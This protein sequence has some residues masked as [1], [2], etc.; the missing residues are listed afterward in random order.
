MDASATGHTPQEALLLRLSSSGREDAPNM[1]AR[2][3]KMG[4]AADTA[5]AEGFTALASAARVGALFVCKELLAHGASPTAPT[6]ENRNPPLFWAAGKG[7][8]EVVRLLCNASAS[9][10][11]QRNVQGDTALLWACR[12][13][14]IGV[15]ETLLEYCPELLGDS[16]EHGL[17]TLMCAA[18]GGHVQTLQL[19]L[20]RVGDVH[21]R[22]LV[23]EQD[24]H[25]RTALHFAV[26]SEACVAALLAAGADWRARDV[27]GCTP[28]GEALK[29]GYKRTAELLQR[30]WEREWA[31]SEHGRSAVDRGWSWELER[32]AATAEGAP[33]APCGP[34]AS[35]PTKRKKKK[36]PRVRTQSTGMQGQL[37]ATPT[38]EAAVP[39]GEA[40]ASTGEAAVPTGVEAEASGVA[41]LH[42]G[43]AEAQP[44]HAQAKDVEKEKDDGDDN[45]DDDAEEESAY[46]AKVVTPQA[47]AAHE[48]NSRGRGS[49]SGADGLLVN[50][51]GAEDEG[52]V[53]ADGW[54]R[55]VHHH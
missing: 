25:G 21:R 9:V 24:I 6:H 36:Q 49:D 46:M 7:H 17:S 31:A 3:L 32:A 27:H 22:A 8:V 5:N 18:V 47:A 45:D 52:E 39:T 43:H 2:L 34:A 19:I 26:A 16:N 41:A 29:E 1:V 51:D 38:G 40:A 20:S 14:Q 10:A 48:P 30:E 37:A 33:K 15:A 13:G 4:V 55:V 53:D 54:T 12:G 44:K 23:D 42:E 28:L 50:A 35:P 11:S